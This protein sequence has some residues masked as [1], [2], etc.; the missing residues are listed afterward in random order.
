VRLS[1]LKLRQGIPE[2]RD[3]HI[4]PASTPLDLQVGRW[5]LSLPRA[6]GEKQKG[7]RRPFQGLAFMLLVRFPSKRVIYTP[8]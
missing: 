3:L 4:T 5:L 7:Q 2:E 1:L 6:F 8:H